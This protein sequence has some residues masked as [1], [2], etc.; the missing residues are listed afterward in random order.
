MTIICSHFDSGV[1]LLQRQCKISAD[2]I[3]Q[4]EN[5]LKS[6]KESH[7][8]LKIQ[9]NTGYSITNSHRDDSTICSGD[10]PSNVADDISQTSSSWTEVHE[11][12]VDNPWRN[13]SS[14]TRGSPLSPLAICSDRDSSHSDFKSSKS[15][16]TC[17]L[18][19][20][21]DLI[22]DG[23]AGMGTRLIQN[24]A[25][26][27]DAEGDMRES[28]RCHSH[29]RKCT[30]CSEYGDC[31][32]RNLENNMDKSNFCLHDMLSQLTS[33]LAD[34]TVEA[35]S[36]SS[37]NIVLEA[38]I[39]ELQAELQHSLFT[40]GKISG[41]LFKECSRL[42]W[43]IVEL[44]KGFSAQLRKLQMKE[45]AEK[46]EEEKETA[47]AAAA[48]AFQPIMSCSTDP[49]TIGVIG[50]AEMP[51]SVTAS[52]RKRGFKLRKSISDLQCSSVPY[53]SSPSPTSF[54]PSFSSSLSL[55]PT[56]ST[57]CMAHSL[58]SPCPSISCTCLIPAPTLIQKIFKGQNEIEIESGGSL[59][60]SQ[61]NDKNNSNNKN[62]SNNNSNSDNSDNNKKQ[63][64][65]FED[66]VKSPT[67]V[68]DI[69]SMIEQEHEVR[70]LKSKLKVNAEDDKMK[71]RKARSREGIMG[72]IDF[73]EK[74]ALKLEI[75]KKEKERLLA[76]EMHYYQLQRLMGK[77]SE[78]M[79]IHD[80]KEEDFRVL[81]EGLEEQLMAAT[82]ALCIAQDIIRTQTQ[83]E[84]QKVNVLKSESPNQ[85]D[86]FESKYYMRKGYDNA[87]YSVHED[88]ETERAMAE[89]D[90]EEEEEG[91]GLRLASTLI[92]ISTANS[93][94]KSDHRQQRSSDADEK[95]IMNMDSDRDRD[96]NRDNKGDGEQ[97]STGSADGTC[98]SL[99][100]D[101]KSRTS[102]IHSN[103]YLSS[104]LY[105]ELGKGES[106]SHTLL[107]HSHSHSHS[108]CLGGAC[109]DIVMESSL[110]SSFPSCMTSP[111]TSPLSASP[112]EHYHHHHHHHSDND[113]D[114]DGDDEGE[115]G[116]ENGCGRIRWEN[117]KSDLHLPTANTPC[118]L[119]RL[120]K[121]VALKGRVSH[122]QDIGYTQ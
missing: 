120:R 33:A 63:Y 109:E 62:K 3:T 11:D 76:D 106:A 91:A 35:Q 5:E 82:D 48:V 45:D 122:D 41:E 83:T 2:R 50:G 59:S 39:V 72:T 14:P 55:S 52:S 84:A 13:I 97:K 90:E 9:L 78:L 105:M 8:Q 89:E 10:Y 31:V 37:T 20:C 99:H 38:R 21:L 113:N 17:R 94:E 15:I 71:Y 117:D 12:P 58:S 85:P 4:L 26:E 74:I 98:D 60:Q 107:S 79:G 67:S 27:C 16:C 30:F 42:R 25:I 56:T 22:C 80:T 51:F 64:S 116:H 29:C 73:E 92:T 23:S 28:N 69:V 7:E 104:L 53:S 61:P 40:P 6:T 57:Y 66:C 32:H 75:E 108:H 114:G 103:S 95:R 44:E 47:A 87:A 119:E 1:E 77:V 24:S 96:R 100:G 70:E 110:S 102:A 121:R 19:P 65:A 112:A 118:H 34:R 49:L 115:G 43:R 93:V 101:S 36:L 86:Y 81:V 54:S 111:A 46:E 18:S 88:A 68:L